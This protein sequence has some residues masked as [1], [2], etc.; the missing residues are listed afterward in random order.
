MKP[1][2]RQDQIICMRCDEGLT[3]AEVAAQLGIT[4]YCVHQTIHTLMRRMKVRNFYQVC[5][6]HGRATMLRDMNGGMA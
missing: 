6:A 2:P 4:R 1:T 5:T 3:Y